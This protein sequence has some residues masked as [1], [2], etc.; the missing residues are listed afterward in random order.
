MYDTQQQ[1]I[2][3]A[4][5]WLSMAIAY[6]TRAEKLSQKFDNP[7]NYPYSI[8]AS[9]RGYARC[10]QMHD[11]CWSHVDAMNRAYF[12]RKEHENAKKEREKLVADFQAEEDNKFVSFIGCLVLVFMCIL[13]VD[14]WIYFIEWLAPH[15]I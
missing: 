9:Y 15:L 12:R 5:R 13:F 6:Q 8:F 1:T 7:S 11:A 2:Q 14:V 10:M 4:Q 3:A